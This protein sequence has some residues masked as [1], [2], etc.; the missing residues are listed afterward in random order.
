MER[1]P[2][3]P[4]QQGIYVQSRMDEGGLSYHMPGAFRLREDVD[5]GR[6]EGA[7]RQL[8]AEDP[9]FRTEFVQEQEGIFCACQ[10][11]GGIFTADTEGHRSV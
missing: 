4:I 2:L 5:T 1:Y 7:F 3:S 11:T 9:L 10:R 6:L 8:I